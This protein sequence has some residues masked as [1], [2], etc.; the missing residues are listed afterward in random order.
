MPWARSSAL[1]PTCVAITEVV[2]ITSAT[3]DASSAPPPTAEVIESTVPGITSADGETPRWAAAAAVIGPTGSSLATIGGSSAASTP[4]RATSSGSYAT[5]DHTRLSVHMSG[6]AVV[7]VATM[8]SESRATNASTGSTN[9]ATRA[10]TSGWNAR[11]T[12]MCARSSFGNGGR[13]WRSIHR[14]NA[15]VS[16]RSGCREPPRVSIHITT[17]ASGR[18]HLSIATTDMYCAVT[19]TAAIVPASPAPPT[20][21]REQ[22]PIACHHASASCSAAPSGV[23]L[24]ANGSA[25]AHGIAPSPSTT[26]TFTPVVP[27]SMART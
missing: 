6:K 7:A 10:S 27:R 18:P 12:A 16:S 21:A 25:A 5:R 26:A 2:P 22:R 9:A 13:P 20:A 15:S 3:R 24:V 1:A 8:R 11:S 14:P 17:G 19:A 23:N 4:A